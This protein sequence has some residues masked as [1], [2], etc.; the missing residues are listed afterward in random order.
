[1]VLKPRRLIRAEQP[2][3]QAVDPHLDEVWALGSNRNQVWTDRSNKD[4]VGTLGSNG[5]K[6]RTVGSDR[7]E[8]WAAQ[9][10]S[11]KGRGGPD[12]WI[13]SEGRSGPS[14]PDKGRSRRIGF[15]R[16]EGTNGEDSVKG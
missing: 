15:R 5:D 7:I 8:V 11:S 3:G 14:D 10:R 12:G 9:G 16:D 1:M 2:Q 6:V 4:K 13:H